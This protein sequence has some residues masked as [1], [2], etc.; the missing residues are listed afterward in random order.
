MG[1]VIF[2]YIASSILVGL[3]Q[4]NATT[5]PH[6]LSFFRSPHRPKPL[7]LSIS[8]SHLSALSLSAPKMGASLPPKEA[9]LFKL[10][11]VSSDSLRISLSALVYIYIRTHTSLSLCFLF[12]LFSPLLNRLSEALDFIPIVFRLVSGKSDDNERKI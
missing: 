6:C 8:L 12:F 3:Q 10:I 4:I 7:F 5:S 9:N 1:F 11:V 2:L